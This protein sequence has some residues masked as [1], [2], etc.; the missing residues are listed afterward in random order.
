MTWTLPE[1]MLATPVPDP[2]LLQG[3]ASEPKRGGFRALFFMDA[4]RVVRRSRLGTDM[5]RA[6]PE[7]VAGSGQLPDATALDGVM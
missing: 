5:V 4:G 7:I 6:F 2:A 3:W 1:P